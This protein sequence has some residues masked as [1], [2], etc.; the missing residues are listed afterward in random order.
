MPSLD[1]MERAGVGLARV[2]AP[3]PRARGRSGS[4]SARATTAATAW[5]SR[6]CCARRAARST[7]WPWRDSTSSGATRAPTSSA[8]PAPPRRRSSRRPWTGSGVV[9]D[10]LLGTG[11]T[12]EP[13]E[14]VGR[15]DRRDQRPGRAGGGVRR[16]VGRG[17]LLGRGG[18]RGGAGR[19]HGHLPRL[20]GR[21]C[22]WR[23]ARSTPGTVEIVEIGVPRGAP[24]RRAAG[25]D[26]PSA[27]SDLYPHRT[28]EGSKFTSGTVVIAGGGPRP[29]RARRP[30][31]RWP[32][33]AP[34]RATCRWRCP[35]SAEQALSLRLLEAMTQRRCP[36]A[37]AA[38][39]CPPASRR[40]WRWPSGPA[41]W[42]SGPGLGR[43]EARGRS[44]ARRRGRS[45]APLL[46][47]ADGLNAHAGALEALRERACADGA[48][49]A[50]GRAGTP[51]GARL[52][53]RRR[54]PAGLRPRGGASA[55]ARWCCSRATTRSWPRPRARW[56]SAPAARRRW[57]RRAPATCSPGLIGALLAKGLGAVRGRRAGRAR[58]RAGRARGRGAPRRGPRGRGRRDR[59]AA[60]RPAF[61]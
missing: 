21:A 4:W 24:G 53:G 5:W 52:G 28:R 29:D 39:T 17:R 15:R 1:L 55:A 49:P 32:P 23:P 61:G 47:D 57:P 13:R 16:A 60:R 3:R 19:R 54:A 41:R 31:P 48:D 36:R 26:R 33:S 50:R 42:C 51:A 22:T 56:R 7:C 12:G 25:P 40:C 8:C 30:W 9:V 27:C 46:V 38:I 45:S 58:P 35:A 37:T 18:G 14:P 11:F 6:G 44:R 34:A 10:A 2:T 59:R 20:Q 43:T